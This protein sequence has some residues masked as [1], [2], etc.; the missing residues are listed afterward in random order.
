MK[1]SDAQ[2]GKWIKNIIVE[3]GMSLS[4]GHRGERHTHLQPNK[5]TSVLPD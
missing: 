1:R 4:N 3:F 2:N 5:A